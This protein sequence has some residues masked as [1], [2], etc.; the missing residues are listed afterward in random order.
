M[1]HDTR[2]ER[3]ALCDRLA[4]VGSDQ[5]T[6]CAGWLT[7]D[8]AA[9]LLLRERRPTAAAGIVVRP[10]AG[11]TAR[12]QRAL[13]RRPFGQLVDRLRTRPWWLRADLV[14]TAVNTLELFVHHE[15]VRRAQPHWQP[16]QL[17]GFDAVLWR[18]VGPLARLRVRQFPAAVVIDAGEHGTVRAGAGG[19]EVRVSGAPGE[20]AMFFTGRQGAARVELTGPDGLVD[21]LRRAR[22]G[23]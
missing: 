10:L 18:R 14:D 12:V 5:P 4:E 9:H 23:L 7:R 21:L 8:L 13:A 3:T 17:P 15:D 16:R 19:P 20:L 1:R 6:L 22:L 11:H 2:A